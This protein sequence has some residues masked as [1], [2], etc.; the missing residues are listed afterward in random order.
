MKIAYTATFLKLLHRLESDLQSEV[1]DKID[2]FKDKKNYKNLNVHKL[3]GKFGGRHSFY[4]NYKIRVVFK[5]IAKEEVIL[6]L[7]GG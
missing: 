5:Y 7:V 6:L 4:V 3:H 2:L 1:I